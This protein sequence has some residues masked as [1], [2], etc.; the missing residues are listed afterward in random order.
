MG[1]VRR[2][3]PLAVDGLRRSSVAATVGERRMATGASVGP[4]R[5]MGDASD[6]GSATSDLALKLCTMP[7]IAITDN[8]VCCAITRLQRCPLPKVPRS[9]R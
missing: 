2:M 5:M 9:P 1:H 6:G 4:W 7:G 3:T 8:A